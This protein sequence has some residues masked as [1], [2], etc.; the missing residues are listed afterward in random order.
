[1]TAIQAAKLAVELG[2]G[3]VSVID[4]L[5]RIGCFTCDPVLEPADA[6]D[7]LGQSLANRTDLARRATGTDDES[8]G[9]NSER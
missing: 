2:L 9:R 7:L 6:P 1:V 8:M 4:A 3:V 5:K